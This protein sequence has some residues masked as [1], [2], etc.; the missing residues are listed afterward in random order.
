M[1]I[2]CDH[3]GRDSLKNK[4]KVNAEIQ[5]PNEITD[6]EKSIISSKGSESHQIKNDIKNSNNKSNNNSNTSKNNTNSKMTKSDNINISN[7]NNSSTNDNIKSNKENNSF[8]NKSYIEPISQ[9]DQKIISVGLDFDSNQE[10]LDQLKGDKETKNLSDS[11]SKKTIKI[12]EFNFEEKKNE[13]IEKDKE[14]KIGCGQHSINTFCLFRS[15]ER[16]TYLVYSVK[17]AMERYIKIYALNMDENKKTILEEHEEIYKNNIVDENRHIPTQIRHFIIEQ[18]FMIKDEYIIAGY[19]DSSIFVWELVN[20]EFNLIVKITKK[21]GPIK[22]ISLFKDKSN[23]ELTI[24][25]SERGKSTI[26]ISNFLKK[27]IPKSFPNNNN[28]NNNNNNIYFLDIHEKNNENYIIVGLLNE[29]ITF[30]YL[31]FKNIKHYKNPKTN[32]KSD[33][34][35]HESIIIYEPQGNLE[36]TKLIDSD[37]E[38]KCIN[39]FNFETTELLLVLNLEISKPLGINIWNNNNM[40]VSCLEDEENNSIKI[41]KVNLNKKYYNQTKVDLN[42]NEDGTE[43]KIVY[44]LKGHEGGTLSTIKMKNREYGEFFVSIGKDNRLK[45]WESQLKEDSMEITLY[46]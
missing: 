46:N 22:G 38:G 4:S 36:E 10:F 33:G 8:I 34:R 27:N 3:S 13:E 23:N 32:S 21:G 9:N 42:K 37:T 41:I 5:K 25:S 44:S 26:T 11:T 28:N 17:N 31:I 39:I 12:I 6:S 14:G 15:I 35:G 45:L 20:S 7:N 30:K 2:I 29:V 18:E 40:I 43:A 1:G 19:R 24:I 16:E